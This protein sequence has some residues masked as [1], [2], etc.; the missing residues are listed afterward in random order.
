[1]KHD[2]PNGVQLEAGA[3]DMFRL[4]HLR[5]GAEPGKDGLVEGGKV[6]AHNCLTGGDG[7]VLPAADCESTVSDR[8][9]EQ[10][11]VA[12]LPTDHGDGKARKEIGVVRKD[13]EAAACIF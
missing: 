13:A 12:A 10:C 3:F 5:V 11:S 4:L 1:M 8:A 6:I 2:L 9:I 7:D